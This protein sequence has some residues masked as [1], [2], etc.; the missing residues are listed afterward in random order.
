LDFVRTAAVLFSVLAPREEEVAVRDDK[1]LEKIWREIAEQ[2]SKELDSDRVA[3]L[4]QKL[5][6]ILDEDTR[7]KFQHVSKSRLK[8]PRK[9]A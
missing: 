8:V 1:A 9:S 5:I 2:V 7:E 6:K 3:R 4:S